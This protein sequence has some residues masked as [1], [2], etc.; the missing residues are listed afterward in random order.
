[1]SEGPAQTRLP[2]SGPV[3]AGRGLTAILIAATAVLTYR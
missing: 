3:G 1:M 2:K